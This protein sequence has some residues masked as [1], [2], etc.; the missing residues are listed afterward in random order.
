[1]K[2][3]VRT[4]AQTLVSLKAS[5]QL[6]ES[7]LEDY[8]SSRTVRAAAVDPSY[9]RLWQTFQ[10]LFE[11]GGKRIRPY[12]MLLSYQAYSHTTDLTP[13]VPAAAA[14]ELLHLAM[15]IHDDIIDRDR[16]RYGIPNVAGQYD[17]HYRPVLSQA[18]ERT[19]FADSA[20]LLAGDLLLS[21]AYE[22]LTRCNVDARLI[23][24]AQTILNEAVFTVVGGE[25]LDTESA[26]TDRHLLRPLEVARF[27][28]ASYSFISPLVMGATFAGASEDELV[29]L[30]ELGNAMGIAYQLQDDLLGTF[31]A[32]EVT[33]KSVVSDLSEDKYTF[34][35][36]LFYERANDGQKAAYESL[37]GRADLSEEQAGTARQ[38][39]I[40]TGAKQALEQHIQEFCRS[41]ETAIE[42]LS[43]PSEH[44]AALHTLL[45][46]CVKRSK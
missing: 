22:L 19:H 7:F 28:T 25:L 17:E 38:L 36:Q 35:V 6:V 15:L 3:P 10:G 46:A 37:A 32:S 45:D 33:G 43:A 9:V 4:D 8:F 26:F 29:L 12:A 41:A 5:K 23:L 24:R 39:L 40:D 2:S 20:A 21:D 44:R 16:V 11:A 31:G 1:M 27:K 42:R 13:V 18:D 14:Q 34:L 30:S